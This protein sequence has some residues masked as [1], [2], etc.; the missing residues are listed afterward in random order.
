MQWGFG[1]VGR[2][3][4]VQRA[5]SEEM[6]MYYLEQHGD[7]VCVIR[8][9]NLFKHIFCQANHRPQCTAAETMTT[10]GGVFMKSNWP[11][12]NTLHSS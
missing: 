4:L 5:L 2:L 11:G 1:G 6:E 8:N 3:D 10:Q 7:R 9:R 12:E